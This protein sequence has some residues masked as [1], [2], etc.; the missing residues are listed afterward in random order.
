VESSR[1]AGFDDL[2]NDGDVDVV[3]LNAKARPTML[4][5]ESSAGNHWLQLRLRGVRS[6]RDGVGARVRVVA[7][8]LAQVAEVHSGRGYQSHYGS[9]L[10]FGLG[11]HNRVESVEVRWPSGRREQF[12]PVAVN[13]Q[14]T[15]TE[16]T[17]NLRN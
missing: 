16:G 10:H 4:R 12:G 5:N 2:D 17:G 14:L 7:G 9:V 1:G 11:A 3:V 15:L 8:G 6:N 13:Q